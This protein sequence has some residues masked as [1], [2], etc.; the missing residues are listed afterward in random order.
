[1]AQF[2]ISGVWKN[3][4]GV[5]THYTIHTVSHTSTTRAV[6]TTKPQAKALLEIQ[7]NNATTWL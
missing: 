5:I 1:M 7:R 6:K 2:R 3:A 4:E